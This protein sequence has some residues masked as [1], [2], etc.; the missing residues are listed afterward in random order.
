MLLMLMMSLL[1]VIV[2]RE[3]RYLDRVTHTLKPSHH[4]PHCR[5]RHSA[6][7]CPFRV[8]LRKEMSLL[9]CYDIFVLQ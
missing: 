1:V 7:I 2:R 9:I 6:Y 8:R 4:L 5:C 3:C